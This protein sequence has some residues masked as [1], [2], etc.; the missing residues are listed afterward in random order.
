MPSGEGTRGNTL[1]ITLLAVYYVGK[2]EENL[3][4]PKEVSAGGYLHSGVR[5]HFFWTLTFGSVKSNALTSP[6]FDIGTNLSQ[7]T[8][9]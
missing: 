2:A 3:T 6:F 9:L 4:S 1:V 8:F 7:V 5:G